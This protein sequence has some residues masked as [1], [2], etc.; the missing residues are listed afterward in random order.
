MW[1]EMI[2]WAS[3]NRR[4]NIRRLAIRRRGCLHP[5]RLYESHQRG[6]DDETD[7]KRTRIAILVGRQSA[8]SSQENQI[9]ER[10]LRTKQ[11][12]EREQKFRIGGLIPWVFSPRVCPP[13]G[14]RSIKNTD[15]V[16]FHTLFVSFCRFVC[17]TLS[18]YYERKTGEYSLRINAIELCHSLN[19]KEFRAR[20]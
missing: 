2:L 17:I 10:F 8:S 13:L 5:T 18:L 12:R 19:G 6:F 3:N 4:R 15:Q 20:F 14:R 1:C 7:W 16:V 11:H 9:R